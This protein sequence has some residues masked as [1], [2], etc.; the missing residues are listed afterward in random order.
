M[1]ALSNNIF[2]ISVFQTRRK[3]TE[4]RKRNKYFRYKKI[5][6]TTKGEMLKVIQEKIWDNTLSFGC[7]VKIKTI[8]WPIIYKVLDTDYKKDIKYW[9]LKLFKNR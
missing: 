8:D 3:N 9:D 7:K 5:T 2:N 4:A 6:M 1:D